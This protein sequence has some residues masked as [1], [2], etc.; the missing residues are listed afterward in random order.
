MNK[1]LLFLLLLILSFFGLSSS[2]VN[3]VSRPN[4]IKNVIL[5]IGD[6]MGPAQI[7]LLEA[8]ARQAQKPVIRSRTTAFS[9]ILKEG[10]KLGVSM[11]YSANVLVTDSA[12]SATQLATGK[13]ANAE[14]IGVDAI[15][16]PS[17]SMLSIAKKSGKA[18]GLVSDV[19]LTHSTPAAFGAHQPSRMLENEIAIDML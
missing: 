19:R 2:D 5:V 18:T 3:S 9:R 17:E 8:Y 13:P 7:G 12:A 10:G 4:K 1:R 14:T 15:G 6:G 16:N 11:T